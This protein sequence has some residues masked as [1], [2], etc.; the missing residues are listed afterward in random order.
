MAE[1]DDL[2][3][4]ADALNGAPPPGRAPAAPYAEIP[5]LDEIVDYLP[6]NGDLPLADRNCSA[7]ACGQRTALAASIPRI[8][9]A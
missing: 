4:K 5:V 9:A 3:S 8:A 2:L 7:R 1:P 6:E